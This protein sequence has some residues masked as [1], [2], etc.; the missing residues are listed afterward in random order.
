M[1]KFWLFLDHFEQIVNSKI[2]LAGVCYALWW[3][4]LV[5]LAFSPFLDCI[6]AWLSVTW[7]LVGHVYQFPEYLYL[8]RKDWPPSWL[9]LWLAFCIFIGRF[10]HFHSF[11]PLEDHESSHPRSSSSPMRYCERRLSVRWLQTRSL[12]I[13][14]ICFRWVI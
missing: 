6:C 1:V 8:P 10:I 3:Y 9:K 5:V 7:L 11:Q 14:I 13:F 12:Y 2:D 4:I